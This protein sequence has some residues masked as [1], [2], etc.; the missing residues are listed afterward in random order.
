MNELAAYERRLRHERCRTDP[1]LTST[2][3]VDV[4]FV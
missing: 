3:R 1:A 4:G 2:Q